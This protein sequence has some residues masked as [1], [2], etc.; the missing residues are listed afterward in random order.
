MQTAT[1]MTQSRENI[2]IV[3]CPIGADLV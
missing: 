2:E 1:K 3:P